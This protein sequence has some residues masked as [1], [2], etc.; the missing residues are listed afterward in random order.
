[1]IT[2]SLEKT[3]L[4]HITLLVLLILAA[5]T[6]SCATSEPEI[7]IVAE[8]PLLTS[9]TIVEVDFA[10][11]EDQNYC[12]IE[13]IDADNPGPS[14]IVQDYTASCSTGF[15]RFRLTDMMGANYIYVRFRTAWISGGFGPYTTNETLF[16]VLY[17]ERA[18]VSHMRRSTFHNF[19]RDYYYSSDLYQRPDGAEIWV[20][21]TDNPVVLGPFE[22]VTIYFSG[23]D[24][25]ERVVVQIVA[26]NS[27]VLSR[28]GFGYEG[29]VHF[30]KQSMPDSQV[31]FVMIIV[32]PNDPEDGEPFYFTSWQSIQL[33]QD[34]DY[35]TS[36]SKR[37]E[38]YRDHHLEAK[39]RGRSVQYTSGK[40]LALRLAEEAQKR[41]LERGQ[42]M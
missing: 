32:Y 26:D 16:H 29:Y 38:A 18:A 33:I 31:A 14:E 34:P 9:G 22:H 10:G 13:L 42:S 5:A 23:V 37:S 11:Y 30:T 39:S 3:M 4:P 6:V 8:A 28:P 25:Y 41:L 12:L 1:M 2:H 21:S 35:S 27:M 15:A 17:L 36:L 19:A 40:P 20:D 24:D 7:R